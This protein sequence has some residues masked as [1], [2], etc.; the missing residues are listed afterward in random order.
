MA[1]LTAVFGCF[2]SC[3]V[4]CCLGVYVT[5]AVLA[6]AGQVGL[7]LYLFIA[8]DNAEEQLASYQQTK[9]QIK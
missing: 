4:R 5:L 9:G 1:I 6:L 3:R 8:P 2:G 7:V